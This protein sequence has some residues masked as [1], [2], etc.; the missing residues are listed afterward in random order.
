MRL[1]FWDKSI[2]VFVLLL[3]ALGF[4]AN[5]T[6]EGESIQKYVAVHVNNELAVEFSFSQHDEAQFTVPF[7]PGNEFEAVLEVKE[8]RVRMLPISRELCPRGICSHTGWIEKSYE[9]IVCVP[10]RIVVSF[11][12]KPGID[13]IDGVTY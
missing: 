11:Q 8:G 10:N 13:D 12:E 2:I 3:S 5:L 6:L 1:T 7:G 4:F 9:T